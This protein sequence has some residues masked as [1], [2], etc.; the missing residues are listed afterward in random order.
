[1]SRND[2]LGVG[3]SS[4]ILLV[5]SAWLTAYFNNRLFAWLGILAVIALGSGVAWYSKN[6]GS[7]YQD[8]AKYSAVFGGLVYLVACVLGL[9]VTRWTH[10]S[11]SPELI[12]STEG[13]LGK[14]FNQFPGGYVKTIMLP[15][16]VTVIF[17]TCLMAVW[18]ALGSSFLPTPEQTKSTSKK[19]KK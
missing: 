6:K 7:S 15:S 3:A 13:L 8:I 5:S 4:S 9:F 17:G 1:M 12:N 2:V 14:L 16:F 11:F 19:G 18:T 10:G